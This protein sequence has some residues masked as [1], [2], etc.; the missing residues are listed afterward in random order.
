MIYY[1]IIII[2]NDD[3]SECMMGVNKAE[4]KSCTAA[5]AVTM[6]MSSGLVT[7]WMTGERLAVSW[8]VDQDQVWSWLET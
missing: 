2:I 4:W 1:H 7:E 3:L 5:L 6:C 8:R